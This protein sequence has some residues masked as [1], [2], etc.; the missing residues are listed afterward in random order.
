MT[1]QMFLYKMVMTKNSFKLLATILVL[2]NPSELK[3]CLSVGLR[4]KGQK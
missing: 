1:S 2:E 4:E 3:D